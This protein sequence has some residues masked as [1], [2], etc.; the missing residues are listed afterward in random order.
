MN[1]KAFCTKINLP[2]YSFFQKLSGVSFY[3][4]STE[5]IDIYID[6]Y[7]QSAELVHHAL[8]TLQARDQ[9]SLPLALSTSLSDYMLTCT[10]QQHWINIFILEWEFCQIWKKK[11]PKA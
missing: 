6:S 3:L 8:W 10:L 1:F 9:G 7:P 2:F 4:I 5:Q 11:E